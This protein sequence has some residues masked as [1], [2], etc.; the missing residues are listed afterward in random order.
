[1]AALRM[2]QLDMGPTYYGWGKAANSRSEEL[3]I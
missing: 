3:E 1:M 2:S